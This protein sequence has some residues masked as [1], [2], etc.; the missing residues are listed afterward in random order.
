MRSWY[1]DT[2]HGFIHTSTDTIIGKLATGSVNEG[3]ALEQSQNTTWLYEIETLK[4]TLSEN[5]PCHVYMEFN[6]PRMG[7]RADVVLLGP[8]FP[9][10]FVIEYK[11]GSKEFLRTDIDQV[12]DYA[13]EFKNFHKASHDAKIIPILVATEAE[14]ES[15]QADYD[16]DN[17]AR[18]ICTNSLGLKQ[19]IDS[20]VFEGDIDGEAWASAPY[21]PTPTIIEA[22]R[23]LYANQ[24]VEDITRSEGGTQNIAVTSRE[25]QSIIDWSRDNKKKSIVFVTGVPGAGKTLVGLN[26][27]T[28]KRAENTLDH[29]VFLSGN[30]PLVKV[31]QEALAR[32]DVQRNLGTRKG[33]ALM[34][35]KTFIQI[36]HH[37]RDAALADDL[38]PSEHVAIFDEA[39]RAWNREQTSNFMVR[40]KNHPGFDSSEPEHLI[41]YMDRHED[42]AVVVCLVGGG[43]EINT[44]EAGIGAWIEAVTDDFPD[45]N[46]FMP[47]ELRDKEYALDAGVQQRLDSFSNLNKSQNLH[48]SVSMRSFRAENVS[49]F[50]KAVLDINS[51]QARDF[52]DKFAN[53]YEI[54]ITRDLHK[55]KEWVRHR[56]RGSERYGL[57]ASSKAMRL[58][59]FAVDVSV[60]A[61]P[62]H[63]FLGDKSDIRSSYFLESVATEFQIQGLELDYTIVGW[64]GDMRL[65][66]DTWSYHDFVGSK[67][68]NINKPERR[69]YVKNAYRVLLTRARQGIVIFIPEGKYPPDATRRPEFYDNTY[70]FLKSIGLPEISV[71]V[72]DRG[73]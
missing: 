63:Y 23:A 37:F 59:P 19:V 39:Q 4:T 29:A 49:G 25:V 24:N 3:F 34:K 66:D 1:S 68:Q 28:L 5:L 47:E 61:N 57:V 32:D 67:W 6:I 54:V 70:E 56:A 2:I 65:V 50:V 33:D 44:G 14:T 58:K 45:W 73:Y 43:Q 12:Y 30:G 26:I 15:L 8:G 31:L 69:E 22:A 62:I 7:H 52:Y 42:W 17:V 46:L 16:T 53:D 38:P 27:A 13:L 55:A 21:Q 11:V 60:E 72:I 48:L 18:P 10:V 35:S 40:K 36:V 41:R 71:G 20:F 64:D 51:D 9:Y